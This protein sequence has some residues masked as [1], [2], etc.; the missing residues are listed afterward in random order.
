MSRTT[1]SDSRLLVHLSDFSSASNEF[2]SLNVT[3]LLTSDDQHIYQHLVD[4]VKG[5]VNIVR[6]RPQ[7]SQVNVTRLAL[8][9]VG[10]D[11]L[12]IACTSQRVVTTI[13]PQ[14]ELL[15]GWL[16]DDE[17]KG[18][19]E[20]LLHLAVLRGTKLFVQYQLL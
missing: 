18:N 10:Q 5:Y 16:Q 14:T 11:A 12:Y 1:V 17:H 3:N 4:V 20:D 6:G 8:V 2:M 19:L 15:Q 9:W 13:A 7:G